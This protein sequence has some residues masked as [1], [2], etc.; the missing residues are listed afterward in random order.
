MFKLANKMRIIFFLANFS[1]GGAAESIVKL[2]EF[3]SKYGFSVLLISINKNQYKKRLLNVGCEIKEIKVSRVLYSFIELRKIIKLETNKKFVKI[4]FFSSIH[5]ANILSIFARMGNKK[6]KLILTERSSFA[7]LKITHSLFRNIK[8]FIVYT[9]SKFFY[10]YSD[11]IITNSNYEKIY[12]K[13]NF[14]IKNIS[15]IHPPSI[16][17]V[18]KIRKNIKRNKITNI[19]FVGR[20]SK[21]KGLDLIVKALSILK[22]TA[23]F[24]FNLKIYG[25]GIEKD[26][27]VYMA[28]KYKINKKIFFLGF[29]KN[30][31]KIFKNADLFINSSYF[32]GLPN[33][34]VQAL[35]YN[36]FSICSDA[37]GGNLEVIKYGK[38]GLTFE[39]GNYFDLASKINLYLKNTYK[40]HSLK[41]KTNHL[42]KYTE[43]ISYNKYIEVIKSI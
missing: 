23:N 32:E 3:L 16:K 41:Y 39:K 36:V 13:K 2:S 4:I 5:Y 29:E 7:E 31:D 12:I 15:C 30:H 14:K 43:M 6:L 1:L 18:F 38:L 28:K 17:K 37:P 24:D 34:L 33:A 42:K 40:M 9:L 22:N 8:N 20:I 11:H 19:I 25:N 21:E 27:I 10:K 26:K 35:N